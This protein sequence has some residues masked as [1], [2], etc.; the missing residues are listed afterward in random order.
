ME[1][2]YNLSVCL[3]IKNEAKYIPE[4]IDHYINQGVDHFYIVSNNSTDNIEEVINYPSYTNLITFIIDNRDMGL[5]TNNSGGRGH[6]QLLDEHFY[7][8]V[9]KETK[10][11][12]FIDADEFMFGKN[13]YT[14]KTYLDKIDDHIGCIYVIW[15]I[16]NPLITEGVIVNSFST[17]QCVKRLNYDLVHNLSW[18]IK[19]ANDFGKSIVRTS[20]LSEQNKL[21]IHKIH[22]TG[23]TINNYNYI[24]NSNYDNCNNISLSEENY[25]KLEISLNH[26]AIRNYDDY[27]KKEKQLT[28]VSDKKAF[29]NGL[30]EMLRLSD[31][32]LVTDNT[33]LHLNI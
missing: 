19:N 10:W 6:K 1:Y 23:T 17:K 25:S 13:G 30:F 2:K 20:M 27:I 31:E 4:F 26:Y 32:Y 18:F 14:I 24:I 29:I 28:A 9:I 7:P 16:I 22:S 11:A 12:I 15:T 3:C 33:F 21:W 5:L 8:L